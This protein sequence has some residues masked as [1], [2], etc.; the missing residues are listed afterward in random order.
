MEEIRSEH[1]KIKHLYESCN[2]EKNR[3]EYE[4]RLLTK[5]TGNSDFESIKLER[6]RLQKEI[7]VINTNYTQLKS[8][9]DVIESEKKDLFSK[10]SEFESTIT[11]KRRHLPAVA[12]GEGKTGA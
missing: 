4:L 10:V 12:E 8:K 6:D 11:E 3:L 2:Q 1:T 5:R 9:Y 7:V